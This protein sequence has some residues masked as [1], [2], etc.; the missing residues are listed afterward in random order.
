M[1]RCTVQCIIGLTKIFQP[2][3]SDGAKLTIE[4]L[5]LQRYASSCS[6]DIPVGIMVGSPGMKVFMLSS[7]QRLFLFFFLKEKCSV[8]G[9]RLPLVISPLLSGLLLVKSGLSLRGSFSLGLT[10][11]QRYYCPCSSLVEITRIEQ[12]APPSSSSTPSKPSS[13]SSRSSTQ[14]DGVGARHT[15]PVTRHFDF[16]T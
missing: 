5:N 14:R 4:S 13:S 15:V 11:S 7:V 16:N 10:G 8:A 12:R 2:E 1:V 6:F 9:S 3:N